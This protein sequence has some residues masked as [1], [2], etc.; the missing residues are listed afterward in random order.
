[1]TVSFDNNH[2]HTE[3][4]ALQPVRVEGFGVSI[5]GNVL[6]D[7]VNIEFPDRQ[8]T[9]IIGPSGCGKSTLLRSINRLNDG[10][11]GLVV[12]GKIFVGDTDIYSP[13]VEVTQIRQRMGLLPQRPTP[14]PMSIF[15]NVAYGCR[16]H[17]SHAKAELTE[18]VEE[19]LR[20]VGLWD[21]VCER[22]HAP[23]SALSIGQQ[24]R[25]C[26][27]RGLAI[28]PKFI[29]G[30]E[31]TSALDPISSGLVEN[32]FTKLKRQYGIILVT[33]T[34]HQAA[35]I[36]DKVVFMQSGRVVEQGD[37]REVLFDPREE[38]TRKYLSG[39]FNYY[40]PTHTYYI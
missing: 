10:T 26:L 32:L 5:G 9:C 28:K 40:T 1:M 38:E 15:D 29:L 18:I 2:T 3:A 24:Q 33:H 7:D 39:Q 12:K 14:L 23:A 21:E 16:L 8:I 13:D 11:K 30:D 19:N 22:L 31:S 36:A 37:A 27:A 20:A 35:R 4:E 6:L 25:L 17:G 34:L